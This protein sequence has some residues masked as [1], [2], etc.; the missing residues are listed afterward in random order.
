MTLSSNFDTLSSAVQQLS[1]SIRCP[2]RSLAIIGRINCQPTVCMR[3]LS[4]LAGGG[5]GGPNGVRRKVQ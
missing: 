3:G 2:N 5:S 1:E 4:G